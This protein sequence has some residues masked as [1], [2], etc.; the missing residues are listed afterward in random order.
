MPWQGTELWL[1]EVGD[2]GTLAA[3]AIA[4]GAEEAI[5]QPEWSPGGLLHFVSDR[6]GWWNLYRRAARQ[7][8]GLCPREAEFASPHWTFG[9]SMYGFRSAGEIV[10]TYI[11]NGVSRLARLLHGQRQAG[12]D[13]QSVRG[14]PRAA[15][16]RLHRCWAARR[17]S[18]WSWRASTS[19]AARGNPGALD[20]AAAGRWLCRAADQHQLSQ[21]QRPHFARLL[22]PADAMRIRAG[23]RGQQLPP[24]MVISH[25][26]PTGM[27][28]STLKLA[29]QFWTSRGFAVLDVNY[30]GS[31]G[32]G[33]AYRDLL[34]GQ[35]GV[36]DVEDC[37]A[38][39]R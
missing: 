14:D 22:L 23:A 38:G 15:R 10:C 35:W 17:P 36:V 30:G 9:G 6:S 4:G 27:A 11:E 18:R 3:A 31:T 28:S 13:R 24:L 2:D 25:G 5:C 21:R 8:T 19:P 1:A 32:F 37:V 33:R 16:G 20:R 7:C 12:G 29:T 34:K 26:G 39:A